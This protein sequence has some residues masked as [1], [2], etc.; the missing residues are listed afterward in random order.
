M[1]Q[2]GMFSLFVV[3]SMRIYHFHPDAITKALPEQSKII[4]KPQTD[5]EEV[6]W[7]V[8]PLRMQTGK[9]RN[10]TTQYNLEAEREA[11]GVV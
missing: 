11:R 9:T 1:V 5:F 3:W 7:V 6:C 8:A 10:I 2:P 4:I